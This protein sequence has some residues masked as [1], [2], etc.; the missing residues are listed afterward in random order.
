MGTVA[1]ITF[2]V[3]F[4]AGPY[5][6]LL[7]SMSILGYAADLGVSVVWFINSSSIK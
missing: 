3:S 5:C 4:P 2:K 6:Q 7:S 1:I